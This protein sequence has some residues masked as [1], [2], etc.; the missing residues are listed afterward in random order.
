MAWDPAQYQRYGDERS[1]PFGDLLARVGAEAPRRVVD[2]GCGPGNL[3]A[4]LARRWPEAEVV[5]LDS[6]EPMLER[7]RSLTGARLRFELGDIADWD[8]A[9]LRPDVIVANAS[10]Q[11]V[12]GHLALVA[13]W[14]RALPP[15]GWLALQV[16]AN[17]GAPSHALMRATAELPHWRPALGGVLRHADAVHELADYDEVLADAGCAV[18]AWDT[19]Y[20]HV[21]TGD[22]PVLEWVRG[23]GLRPALDALGGPGSPDAQRFEQE[24][25]ER[26]RTAY[27]STAHGTPFP[28][29]RRFAVAHRA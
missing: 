13:S 27:P 4:Q 12:P 5:G 1:R 9:D 7:A 19:T 28:F 20:L 10:L 14:A 25:A 8:P 18:D 21:L 22:D 15:D 24:Y 16:P 11:W 3:P 29:A 23:T 2:L 26:L 17:F 6:S